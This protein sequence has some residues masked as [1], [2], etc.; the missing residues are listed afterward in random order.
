MA[1]P[2]TRR[3]RLTRSARPRWNRFGRDS[4]TVTPR[5]RVR[6]TTKPTRRHG[7]CPVIDCPRRGGGGIK[8]H[9]PDPTILTTKIRTPASNSTKPTAPP[10]DDVWCSNENVPGV[11][12]GFCGGRTAH[13]NGPRHGC[14]G[15]RRSRSAN[16]TSLAAAS[17]TG[18]DLCV[19]TRRDAI[20]AK[21]WSGL[22]RR[23]NPLLAGACNAGPVKLWLRSRRAIP[24]SNGSAS[25]FM[26]AGQ[27][28]RRSLTARLPCETRTR[29]SSV[30]DER[31]RQW[32]FHRMAETV[33]VLARKD[34]MQYRFPNA[35]LATQT[36]GR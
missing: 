28:A 32:T 1:T 20:G 34:R 4:P 5:F 29:W 17:Q 6:P 19:G 2:A 33:H 12:G 13:S 11:V 23:R 8:I 24:H 31:E 21:P 18:R 26:K 14:W 3:S 16:P 30:A 35:G 7:W 22:G 10:R 9:F 15:P 27:M 25:A 36:R